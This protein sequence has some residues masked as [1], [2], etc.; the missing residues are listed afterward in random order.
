MPD[1]QPSYGDA[2][3]ELSIARARI[4]ELEGIMEY[5]REHQSDPSLIQ[6]VAAQLY[7][8]ASGHYMLLSDAE[9]RM[10]ATDLSQLAVRAWAAA[11]L[12]ARAQPAYPRPPEPKE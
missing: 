1:G 10:P 12:F 6:G 8:E 7:V 3:L 2:L 9:G 11:V 4:R 5:M